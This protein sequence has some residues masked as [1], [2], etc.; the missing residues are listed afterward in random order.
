MWDTCTSHFG[1]K[2]FDR[3]GRGGQGRSKYCQIWASFLAS[4]PSRGPL[5]GPGPQ[6]WTQINQGQLGGSF[7]WFFFVF[8]PF[9]RLCQ[10]ITES[11]SEIL[12][13]TCPIFTVLSNFW[14]IACYLDQSQINQSNIPVMP[15]GMH[16]LPNSKQTVFRAPTS[17]TML[18]F[19][20]YE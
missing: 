10:Q 5:M 4:E 2:K 3:V 1:P 15:L 20:C 7:G 16:P 11:I 13:Q 12:A 18:D 17:K 14:A 9:R 8:D 6:K 19:Y